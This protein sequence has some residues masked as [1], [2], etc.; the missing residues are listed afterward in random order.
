MYERMSQSDPRIVTSCKDIKTF[1]ADFRNSEAQIIRG[2]VIRL[3]DIQK[4]S[5]DLG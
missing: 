3:E 2:W 1:Q 4:R 5:N